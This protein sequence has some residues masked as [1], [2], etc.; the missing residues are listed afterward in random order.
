MQC[1]VPITC[2][3]TLRVL[4]N[5]TSLVCNFI[6]TPFFTCLLSFL[7]CCVVENQSNPTTMRSITLVSMF[8]FL[9]YFIY[10]SF[11]ISV[12]SAKCLEDQQSL[13]LQIKNNLTFEADCFNKLEQWNQSIPCCNWHGVT[14]DNERQVIGLDQTR[15]IY[16]GFDNSTGLFSLQKLTKIRMLYL[17]GISIPAQGYEWSSLLLPLRDLQELGMSDCGFS[18]PLDSS[19]ARLENLSV[20][21]LDGNNFS[22]PVPETFAN[23]KNLT[24]LNLNDCGLTGT[25]P[26]N[27]FQI[28][29]LS[30]ID[31]SDNPNLH[32]FFSRLL[33]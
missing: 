19:L 13:L 31:L 9:L 24:T 26:Q 27:I 10:M 6:S 12:A 22:S 16:G 32:G 25:F 5:E 2:V 33:T 30:D 29:T 8:S 18:G 20:I 23:F 17:D 21:L 11:Q 1:L 4:F 14:C 28:R 3:T 15:Q 7:L